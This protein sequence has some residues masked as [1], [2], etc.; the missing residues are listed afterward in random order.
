VRAL[1]D[2]GSDLSDGGGILSDVLSV[3][4]DGE[5]ERLQKAKV[6]LKWM[7]VAGQVVKKNYR[8]P[9]LMFSTDDPAIN[10]KMDELKRIICLVFASD[11]EAI[12]DVSLTTSEDPSGDIYFTKMMKHVVFYRPDRTVV[13]ENLDRIKQ[14]LNLIMVKITTPC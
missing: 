11:P 8:D 3:A 10:S 9:W 5:V 1:D 13:Y 7:R 14:H 2:G 12:L 6:I 4:V